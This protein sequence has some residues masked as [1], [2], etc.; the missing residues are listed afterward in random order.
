MKTNKFLVL[1]LVAVSVIACKKDEKVEEKVETQK[2][3]IFTFTLNAIVNT[4]DDFQIF[5][6]EDND[7]QIPFEETSSVWSGGIK[8]SANAQDIIFTLPE[9]VYP[10]QIRLDFGQ[11]KHSEIVINSFVASF[12]EKSFTLKGAEFFNFF[13]ID[14]N[15]VKTDRVAAKIIPIEQA[16]GKF[17]PMLYSN[18]DFTT[19]LSKI[20]Q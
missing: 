13:T 1:L 14:E 12:K 11:N 19:E 7:P 3:E 17:D 8:A 6:K 18:T 4:D 16:D 10:T 15:F 9:G 20:S 5:Y 2:P